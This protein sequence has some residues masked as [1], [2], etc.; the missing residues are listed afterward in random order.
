M[1]DSSAPE[2][3]TIVLAAGSSSRMGQSKQLLDIAGTPLLRHSAQIALEAGTSQTIVV[4]GSNEE[5]H[6]KVIT[7]LP[8]D[9]VVNH[10]WQAGMGSSIKTG[11]HYVIREYPDAKAV[12]MMV[13]DQPKITSNHLQSLVTAYFRSGKKIIAS[14]YG[15][16]VGVPA[17]FGRSFFSNIL[18]LKDNEGAK[19]IIA[20]FSDLTAALPF[21]DG[22]MDLDTMDD[23]NNF[24][25]PEPSN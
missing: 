5:S 20:Q 10:Y 21:P 24:Q 19:K 22:A 2:T 4:L 1:K 25:R 3:V 7:D 18:M 9:I 12:L 13:C 11:L 16:A 6:R 14:S 8:V 15:S 17:V 23:Y